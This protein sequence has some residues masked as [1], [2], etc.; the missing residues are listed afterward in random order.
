MSV[1]L[2]F[3]QSEAIQVS[4]RYIINPIRGYEGWMCLIQ[5]DDMK[6]SVVLCLNQSEAMKVSVG[7]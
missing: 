5:S 3:I 2:C 6:V 4:V 1:G 7:L